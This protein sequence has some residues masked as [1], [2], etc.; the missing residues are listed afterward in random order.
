MLRRFT[1]AAA[2]IIAAALVAGTA[3]AQG[4]PP[5]LT[6]FYD[7]LS[8]DNFCST[9]GKFI[10]GIENFEEGIIPPGGK[11]CFPAPIG[12]FPTPPAFPEGLFVRN[13]IIQDNV[14]PGPSPLLLNPS[15]N[16]CALYIIGQGFI[17]ANSIKIGEDVFLNGIN[18]SLDLILTEPAHTGVGFRLS[19]FQGFPTGGWIVTAYNAVGAIIGVFNVPPPS[20]NEPEKDFFG[21]WCEGGIARVNIFDNA[22]VPAPDAIDDIELW[23]DF[24][25]ATKASTWGRL[26]MTYR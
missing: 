22:G 7:Q 8:F 12:P 18:A 26:R 17:G 23:Q 19:R 15:G 21:I 24:E 3:L 1:L 20:G 11:T 10:K 9:H 6:A 16:G 13:I 5:C 25:T 4:A 14:T 2:F